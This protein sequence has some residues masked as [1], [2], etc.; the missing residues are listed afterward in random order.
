MAHVLQMHWTNSHGLASCRLSS[1]RAL[2][3]TAAQAALL[4]TTALVTTLAL[5]GRTSAIEVLGF[6]ESMAE[7][8]CAA[9]KTCSISFPTVPLGK[10]LIATHID[11]WVF[12]N[13]TTAPPII[14]ELSVGAGG[15]GG[16]GVPVSAITPLEIGAR[17]GAAEARWLQSSNLMQKIYPAR[18]HPRVKI[19]LSEIASGIFMRCSI[20]GKMKTV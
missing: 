13:D 4:A 19:Q 20:A 18:S 8:T 16:I 1:L 6:Y 14:T 3:N 17:S 7:N 9:A 5:T 15:T 12:I 10:V 11:C 2:L